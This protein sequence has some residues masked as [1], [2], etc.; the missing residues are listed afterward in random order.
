LILSCNLPKFVNGKWNFLKIEFNDIITKKSV[1]KELLKFTKKE[2]N[3]SDL[4]IVIEIMDAVGEIVE[5]WLIIIDTIKSI[6]FGDLS[7]NS[8]D[9]IRPI[10][11]VKPKTCEI[12]DF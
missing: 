1:A 9:L 8:L 5:K 2:I 6:D 10:L 7:Y 11:L 3:N 12:I 4:S